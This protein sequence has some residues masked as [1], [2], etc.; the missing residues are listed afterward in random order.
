MGNFIDI[1]GNVYGRLT[2]IRR[3]HSDMRKETVWIC[4][5]S[6]GTT[7]N[8]KSWRLKSGHTSSCGCLRKDT[9]SARSK[10]HGKSCHPLYN[11]YKSMK[12]RC[13]STEASVYP[14]YLSKG[15][16]VC[17]RWLE[18]VDN[19]IEDMLE[20][21]VGGL[22]LDRI[23][24]SRGY[25][26]ENCR[27]VTP[28]QNQMNTGSRINSTSKYKGVCWFKTRNKWVAQIMI[29][30]KNKHLGY[31][32]DERDAGVAYNIAAKELFG[33]YANLNDIPA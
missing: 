3:S 31:F 23:D 17:E 29:D 8:A 18:S 5:C 19:F 27:W 20:G 12:G 7:T 1:T 15:I 25:S 22:Q 11:A 28:Q 2:V 16:K 21:Y 13:D 26:P 33:E 4:Q 24:A 10:T 32:V 30:G 6:C 9:L 14:Y